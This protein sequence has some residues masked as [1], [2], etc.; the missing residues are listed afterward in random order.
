MATTGYVIKS[1]INLIKIPSIR[2]ASGITF[3]PSQADPSHVYILADAHGIF[4]LVV[5]RDLI[6]HNSLIYFIP[7]ISVIAKVQVK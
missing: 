6:I 2:Y 3:V 7:V 5:K 1:L 4:H